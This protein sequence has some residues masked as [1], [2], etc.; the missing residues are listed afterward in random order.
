MSQRPELTGN[1]NEFG[2]NVHSSALTLE[3][4]PL[5][6]ADWMEVWRFA[7]TFDGYSVWGDETGAIANGI[8]EEFRKGPSRG[9]A[10]LGVF[11]R[12]T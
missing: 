10:G 4:M 1:E 6:T 8:L 3:M 11:S 9:S 12:S 7:L 2:R 5:D